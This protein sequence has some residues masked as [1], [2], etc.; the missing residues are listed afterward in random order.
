V[1]DHLNLL[2]D[3]LG[4]GGQQR[5]AAAEA[6]KPVEALLA[7]A[8]RRAARLRAAAAAGARAQEG[9][10]EAAVVA[11]GPAQPGA[12]VQFGVEDD[13]ARL[14]AGLQRQRLARLAEVGE[15]ALEGAPLPCVV[16]GV[17]AARERVAVARHP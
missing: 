9:A 10:T 5:A 7:N 13:E 16:E 8:A 11:R 6:D 4:H 15:E 2:E 3:Q 12:S 17:V 1:A 14:V